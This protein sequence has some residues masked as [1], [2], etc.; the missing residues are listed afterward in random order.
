M[1]VAVGFDHRG[2]RLRETVFAALDAEGVD[3]LDLGVE[4]DDVPVDYPDVARDVGMAIRSGR[5]ERGLLVCGSGVGASIAAS[6]IPGIRAASCHDAYSAYQG[7]EHDDMNV[8]CLGSEIVGPSLAYVLIQR[9]L[10]AEFVGEGRYL[11]RLEKVEEL[12]KL[13]DG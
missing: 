9:F 8:L 11:A 3:A 1:K 12:E 13:V 4:T 2:V 6:K 5:A 10:Q 7:V